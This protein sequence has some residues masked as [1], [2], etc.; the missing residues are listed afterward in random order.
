MTSRKVLVALLIAVAASP[1]WGGAEP[2]GSVAS[3]SETTVRDSPLTSGST[4]YSGDVVSVAAH[5]VTRIVLSGGALAE[6]L[7]N[8]SVRL[9]KADG[10]IGMIVDRG[11]ASFHTSGGN[12]MSAFVADATVRPAGDSETSAVIQSLSET[13]AIIAAEKGALLVT[14]AHDAKTFTLAEGEAVDLSAA[15]DPQGPAGNASP[16]GKGSII[17]AH[18]RVVVIAAGVALTTFMVVR[19]ETNKGKKPPKEV[20]P[21]M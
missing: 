20:S 11:Q 9:M 12:G 14:P 4:L 5:G 2:L 16:A 13:H 8:S 18:W 1:I 21:H 3:S 19:V 7:A 17:A 10:K 15:P 6:I